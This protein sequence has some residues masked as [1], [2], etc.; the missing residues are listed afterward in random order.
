M[1][2]LT[3]NLLLCSVLFAAQT[4]APCTFFTYGPNDVPFD[5][6]PNFC[7]RQIIGWFEMY[8]GQ[9]ARC[10]VG[11]CS[12]DDMAVML[13]PLDVQDGM[14]LVDYAFEWQTDSNDVGIHYITIVATA[15]SAAGGTIIFN[16]LPDYRP[17]F[18]PIEDKK[19]TGK[20][21]KRLRYLADAWLE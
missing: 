7:D 12:P 13:Y 15:T 11:V 9:R 2:S 14:S 4:P 8:A 19:Q 5:Y 1:K 20:K 10:T 21:I 6:D 3:V 18:G 16:I 17:I